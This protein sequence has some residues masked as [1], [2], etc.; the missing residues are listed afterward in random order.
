MESKAERF[1][2]II[3]KS[4]H[5]QT[6]FPTLKCSIVLHVKSNKLLLYLFLSVLN[7]IV[8]FAKVDDLSYQDWLRQ[9]SRK[10]NKDIFNNSSNSN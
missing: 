10:K 6:H 1:S 7:K 9:V 8:S 5:H 2:K 4:A 3:L